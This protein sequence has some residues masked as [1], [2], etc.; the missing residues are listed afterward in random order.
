MRHF[1][2]FALIFDLSCRIILQH[3]SFS[4]HEPLIVSSGIQCAWNLRHRT[5]S[6]RW[7][8]SREI[9]FRDRRGCQLKHVFAPRLLFKQ[10]RISLRLKYRGGRPRHSITY[11]DIICVI[12]RHSHLLYLRFVSSCNRLLIGDFLH[13]HSRVAIILSSDYYFNYL[14]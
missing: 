7:P 2:N 6:L 9:R 3:Y 12:P 11:E 10:E 13:I 5:P 1:N 4:T 14:P 8:R